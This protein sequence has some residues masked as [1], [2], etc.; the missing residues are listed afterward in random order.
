VVADDLEARPEAAGRHAEREGDARVTALIRAT[1][2]CDRLRLFST[3][4]HH[5]QL[6]MFSRRCNE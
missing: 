1:L 6:M 2:K 4:D 3:G 5:Q